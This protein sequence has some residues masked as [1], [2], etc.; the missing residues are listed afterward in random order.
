MTYPTPLIPHGSDNFG[1]LQETFRWKIP[2]YFN[3]AEA[4]CDRHQVH[5]D[6]VAL[7]WEDASGQSAE[8][9]F[10]D[11][12]ELSNRF[13]NVLVGLGI[14]AGDRVGIILPQRV[15]AAVCHL[16]AWKIGAISLPLSVLFLGLTH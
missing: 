10:G 7:Y 2:E 12:I 1:V 8:Y 15:E 11:L 4:V 3:I 5:R 16:A 13:A 6:R 14:Q 9:T